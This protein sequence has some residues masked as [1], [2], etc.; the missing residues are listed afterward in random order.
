MSDDPL[1]QA[2]RRSRA[3]A[4]SF[5]P[6]PMTGEVAK[7]VTGT[8][9]R[10]AI[11]LFQ[12]MRIMKAPPLQKVKMPN[13]KLQCAKAN[14]LA[15]YSLINSDKIVGRAR[16]GKFAS[17]DQ[18]TRNA[19]HA[20]ALIR[21]ATGG[22]LYAGLSLPRNLSR[23]PEFAGDFSQGGINVA[24]DVATE[25]FLAFSLVSLIQGA[26]GLH[27]AIQ[28]GD[29]QSAASTLAQITGSSI[30]NVR[31]VNGVVKQFAA[32]GVGNAVPFLSST[33]LNYLGG[34]GAVISLGLVSL[35]MHSL[36]TEL[37]DVKKACV[38]ERKLLKVLDQGIKNLKKGDAE[39][40]E[41]LLAAVDS[42]TY[43][44]DKP[45]KKQLS[46]LIRV[47]SEGMLD[48]PGEEFDVFATFLG[49]GYSR[50]KLELKIEIAERLLDSIFE[51]PITGLE[52]L[53]GGIKDLTARE[54]SKDLRA[55][56]RQQMEM[57]GASKKERNLIN[58]VLKLKGNGGNIQGSKKLKSAYKKVFG[59]DLP[60][61]LSE[62]ALI[63]K[64]FDRIE[65]RLK[66]QKE[67]SRLSILEKKVKNEGKALANV[68]EILGK[69]RISKKDYKAA[70]RILAHT[71]FIIDKDQKRQ[72]LA[73]LE[74]LR[75][76]S[77]VTKKSIPSSVQAVLGEEYS[78]ENIASLKTDVIQTAMDK[79][80]EI[81]YIKSRKRMAKL[82]ML[83]AI[84]FAA[85]SI[86]GIL[87]ATVFTG[88]GALIVSAIVF[89]SIA[90][91]GAAS[92]ITIGGFVQNRGIKSKRKQWRKRVQEEIRLQFKPEAFRL[93]EDLREKRKK[94]Y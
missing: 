27:G 78:P 73:K 91:T 39:A 75:R 18:I 62:D 17:Q 79:S 94:G 71:G 9:K 83:G 14:Q 43:A 81:G 19:K 57:F 54:V 56:I 69:E 26:R 7:P 16:P 58:E 41:K 29:I 38:D 63:E 20:E 21:G 11:K 64:C 45:Q 87:A 92:A 33:V 66:E 1:S 68:N 28:A 32:A 76:L 46:D 30:T 2:G 53:K 10:L 49:P 80:K 31:A 22:M 40:A 35:E 12:K 93:E 86:T 15:Y 65:T 88:G 37:R 47:I 51:I 72:L 48:P 25:S 6:V 55:D 82:K 36:A 42:L 24:G 74:T 5:S 61:D 44:V 59:E 52:N 67:E 13:A 60:P 85:L 89:S 8:L 4:V 3:D 77:Q 84:C 23:M 90:A 70:K 34:A 50:E